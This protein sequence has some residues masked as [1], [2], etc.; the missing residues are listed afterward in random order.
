VAPGIG[1]PD[2]M[3]IA[4]IN[5]RVKKYL[6][7]ATLHPMDRRDDASPSA[8]TKRQLTSSLQVHSGEDKP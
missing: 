7:P 1:A 6:A 8:C 5:P 2:G 3:I 4:L